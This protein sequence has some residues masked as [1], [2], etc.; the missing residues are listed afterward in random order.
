M[1]IE[2]KEIK[3]N[4]PDGVKWEKF[5]KHKHYRDICSL[6]L[7]GVDFAFYYKRDLL[8]LEIKNYTPSLES[9]EST[10]I[11]E[12]EREKIKKRLIKELEIKGESK[13]SLAVTL[14]SK[15]ASSTY[16]LFSRQ[17]KRPKKVT[18]CALLRLPDALKGYLPFIDERL[19]ILEAK[20]KALLKVRIV[21]LGEVKAAEN[22]IE[23]LYK[24]E[25]Q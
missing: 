7:K 6:G 13:D 12:R 4:I 21:V 9:I 5:D 11:R 14:A 15:L 19:R 24:K 20:G 2:E 22:I 18:F 1:I 17:L 23:A 3:L 8:L 16:V 10:E 25:A